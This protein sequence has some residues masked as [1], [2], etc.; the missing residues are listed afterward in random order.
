MNNLGV[1]MDGQPSH[2]SG[3]LARSSVAVCC[4]SAHNRGDAVSRFDSGHVHH[5]PAVGLTTCQR[6]RRVCIRICLSARRTHRPDARHV[7]N[8][9]W[10]T[11]PSL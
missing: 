8:D 1:I 3:K 10:K 4:P 5:F 11:I 6:R 2:E 7:A 9:G